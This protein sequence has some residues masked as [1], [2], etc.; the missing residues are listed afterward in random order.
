MPLPR[1]VTLPIASSPEF[2]DRCVACGRERPG[3]SFEVACRVPPRSRFDPP[4]RRPR[5]AF[6]APCC[7]ACAR[8]WRRSRRLR[9]AAAAALA[10]LGAFA[11]VAATRG[12]EGPWAHWIPVLFALPLL[13]PLFVY[14]LLRPPPLALT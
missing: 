3:A 9:R 8:A 2:P 6:A 5:F 10:V 14:E 7:E 4:W 1:C 11:A 13:L 12:Y